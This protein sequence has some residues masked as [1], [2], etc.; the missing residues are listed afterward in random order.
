MPMPMTGQNEP[1]KM[2]VMP[3]M[4]NP[5]DTV[6]SARAAIPVARLMR[7]TA[8]GV[9]LGATLGDVG[10]RA[11]GAPISVCVT[12]G[13]S[14]DGGGASLS[15]VASRSTLI[16]LR[17]LARRAVALRSFR[18]APARGLASCPAPGNCCTLPSPI[19][20]P[21]SVDRDIVHPSI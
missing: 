12:V 4:L 7:A 3:V 1:T 20:A 2:L 8:A 14:V 13:A 21:S 10:T 15:G 5:A 16:L 11:G 6:A 19:V 17:Y 18:R 9:S